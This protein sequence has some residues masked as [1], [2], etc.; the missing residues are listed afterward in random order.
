MSHVHDVLIIGG[1]LSGL[2]AARTL[3]KAGVD[4]HVFE[5]RDRLGGRVLTAGPDG[6]PAGDGFDLGPSWFW[7]DMHPEMAERVRELGLPA[8]GQHSEGDVLLERSAR[9]PARRFPTMRQEPPSM[10]L[11]GGTATWIAA[12]ASELPSGR[13]HLRSRVVAAALTADRVSLTITRPEGDAVFEAEHV[14]FALPPRLLAETVRFHP[15]VEPSTRAR[16]QA[17]ATW[18]AP[19]AKFVA[20]YDRPFW[21]HAGLAGTAQSV[22]GPLVEIHDATTASGAAAL[23]G[24]VGVPAARRAT[25]G[26]RA[27]SL[28]ATAQLARIFGPEAAAPRATLFKDW[29]ADPLTATR[30]DQTPEGHPVPMRGPW[31]TGPWA[32]RALLAGSETSREHPGYLAG[33]IDAGERAARDLLQRR[34]GAQAGEIRTAE[35]QDGPQRG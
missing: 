8:F 5:A 31:L 21:R 13:I 6:L 30:A 32:Q 25:M 17:T 27:L 23:F 20:L 9:E 35:Q 24:F 28:A 16:W 26:E 14:I 3:H 19:H 22:E 2:H 11:V 7:P 15:D 10:R 33:A 12:L 1:G 18:M 29:S 34:T 4:L